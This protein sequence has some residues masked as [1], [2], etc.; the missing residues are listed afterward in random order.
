MS[1]WTCQITDHSLATPEGTNVRHFS[2]KAEVIAAW[3]AGYWN[4]VQC[5]GYW[6][7]DLPAM[8]ADF[9]VTVWRGYWSDVTDAYPVAEVTLGRQGRGVW[10]PIA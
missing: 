6:G 1:T 2:S 5:S 8:G 7:G 10:R 9:T 4:T 3:T